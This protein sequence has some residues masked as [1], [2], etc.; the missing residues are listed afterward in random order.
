MNSPTMPQRTSAEAASRIGG[1]RRVARSV[2]LSPEIDAE[3]QA[4]ASDNSTTPSEII[5]RAL[6]EYMADAL[7]S[8]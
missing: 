4:C 7:Y 3:L 5:R 8:L 1:G 2:R 6:V